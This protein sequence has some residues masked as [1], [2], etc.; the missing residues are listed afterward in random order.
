MDALCPTCETLLGL[1]DAQN[2]VDC[3]D[4][5]GYT[6]QLDFQKWSHN[7]LTSSCHLCTMLFHAVAGPRFQRFIDNYSKTTFEL[8]GKNL[9][10]HDPREL[11]HYLHNAIGFR[12]LV[13]I[14]EVYP[15]SKKSTKVTSL[16]DLVVPELMM[17]ID[18]F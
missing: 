16:M 10:S 17:K 6:A 5:D 11:R 4:P 2:R 12:Q 1:A 9:G 13:Q 15:G 18:V 14:D 8:N 3:V 7:A